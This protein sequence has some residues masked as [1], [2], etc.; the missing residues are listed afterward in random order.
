MEEAC[1]LRLLV[2]NYCFGPEQGKH[3]GSLCW[4]VDAL[5]SKQCK[6]FGFPQQSKRYGDKR[7]NM[8]E[9]QQELPSSDQN[10]SQKQIEAYV[11]CEAYYIH[12]KIGKSQTGRSRTKRALE[13]ASPIECMSSSGSIRG[14]D[15]GKNVKCHRNKS[16]CTVSVCFCGAHL[17][18]VLLCHVLQSIEIRYLCRLACALHVG[19]KETALRPLT[20]GHTLRPSHKVS[21]PRKVRAMAL[22]SPHSFGYW[23]R[24]NRWMPTFIIGVDLFHPT[25][26]FF[27]GR[28]YS[29]LPPLMPA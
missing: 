4:L 26:A 16:Y 5:D 19:D 2:P 22:F 9:C 25:L 6:S 15:G 14:Q 24:G 18:F 23:L 1:T 29:S 11:V 3:N 28:S 21:F 17:Q 7:T 20:T 10:R 27:V 13:D 8:R 12:N